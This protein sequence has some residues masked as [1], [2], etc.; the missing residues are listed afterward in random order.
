MNAFNVGKYLVRVLKFIV[1]YS[2]LILIMLTIVYFT[3]DHS[4]SFRE[5][6][7]P[8]SGNNLKNMIILIVAFSAVYPFIGF[9]KR[10]VHMNRSFDKDKEVVT[11]MVTD[12]GYVLV[13]DNDNKLVF[14]SKR[15]ITRIFRVFE[16]KIVIDYSDNP[17]LVTGLRRDIMRISQHI[18]YHFRRMED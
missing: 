12:M 9:G 2:V 18:Q 5:F 13:S 17:L 7:L 15:I 4:V 1:F 3:S 8:E 6:L 11:G 14:K 16:D 10:E